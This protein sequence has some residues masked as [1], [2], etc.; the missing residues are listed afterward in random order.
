MLEVLLSRLCKNRGGSD[1]HG[2]N[3]DVVYGEEESVG[4]GGESPLGITVLYFFTNINYFLLSTIKQLHTFGLEVI[5]QSLLSS[6][7]GS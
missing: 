6:K 3:I 7:V 1:C 2:I 5:M 4:Q